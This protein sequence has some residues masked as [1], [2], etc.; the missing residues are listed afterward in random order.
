L[1][2]AA[3][4]AAVLPEPVQA[5]A[6]A[7]VLALALLAPVLAPP[8]A[9]V[10]ALA[11]PAPVIALHPWCTWCLFRG[12]PALTAAKTVGPLAF[13]FTAGCA[14]VLAVATFIPAR[15]GWLLKLLNERLLPL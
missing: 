5:L 15:P 3:V 13:G 2:I 10:L 8:R 14:C 11:L 12:L 9:A 7:A 1:A 4:L 6:R